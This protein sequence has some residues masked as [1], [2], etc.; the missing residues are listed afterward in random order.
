MHI[1]NKLIIILLIF[2]FIPFLGLGLI[3]ITRDR[4]TLKEQIGTSSLELS[5]SLMRHIDEYFYSKYINIQGWTKNKCLNGITSGD[6]YGNIFQFLAGLAEIHDEYYYITYL[7]TNGQVVASNNID[8]KGRDM[9]TDAGFKK[10]LNGNQ[11]M[12]DVAFN[13]AAGGYAVVMSTPVWDIPEQ[14]EIIGV[15]T[16]ALKWDVVNEMITSLKIGGKEQTKAN[17]IMLTNKDG[18]VISCFDKKEMFSNNLIEAGMKSAKYAQEHKEGYLTETSEHNLSSFATYTYSRKYKDL[19]HLDWNL[20]L[21]Q[22]PKIV[23]AVAG[24]STKTL[25]ITLL[26]TSTLLIIIS[27]LFAKRISRPILAIVSATRAIGKGDLNTKIPIKSNDEIGLLSISF[28]KMV[29]NLKKSN[30]ELRSSEEQNRNVLRTALDGFWVVDIEGRILEVNDA[31]CNLTGYSREE[32]LKMSISEVEALERPEDTEKHIQQVIKTGSDRFE[33]KHRCKDGRIIDI[34]VSVNYVRARGG[35]LFVFIRD[36]T[37]RK[38][39]EK[40]VHAQHAVTQVLAES[41]TL[42]EASPKILQIICTALEWD[43]GEIWEYDQQRKVLFNTEIW[44]VSSLKFPEFK[45]TTKQITFPPKIGLPGRVW[46]SAEPLWIANVVHDTNFLR[47]SVADKEGLHGAFGF[48]I[49]IGSE[50][51]GIIC[52]FSREIREPD[53]DLLDMMTAIG[54]QIGLFIKRKQ[55]EQETKKSEEKYRK[56]METAQDAILCDINGTITDWNKSA[57]E[58]FGYSK[59]EIIGKSVNILV[60][61]K[62][63]KEHQ[64]GLER[65]LKTGE[66]KMIG[67][68]MEVSGI[69]KEGAE[70]PIEISLTG[71]KLGNERYFFTGIIRDISEK[72]K[73]QAEIIR[74]GQLALIGELA[75]GLA[76]EINNPIY[77][78]INYAQLIADESDKD[79]RAHKFGK[80]I[81]EE[82]NRIADL[83]KKFLSLSR[84]TTDKK[85]YVQIYELISNSLKLTKVQLEK[86]NI[87]IKDN[88]PKDIPAIIANPQEIHQVFLNLI[89]N[90]RYALNEKYP[91]KD[92]DKILEISCNKVLIDDYE[93]VRI[94][95]YDRGIGIPEN[96]LNKI[97]SPFFTTKSPAKGTGIGLSISQNIISNHNGKMTIE[98]MPG[99]FTKVVIDLPATELTIKK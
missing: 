83:T 92:K 53:N 46:E 41:I 6:E 1:R 63:K 16:V 50:V 73:L 99:Q 85:K 91:D 79:S 19:P 68:T 42:E 37:E 3:E 93:Y 21:E 80:L 75:A 13:E 52:F 78:I 94:I 51:L 31:Y 33:S 38:K 22:D 62:Y 4:K 70:I 36:I 5:R 15:L 98:S 66:G 26:G 8:L 54:R 71:Q 17:H 44:H 35:R 49:V 77:G 56:L 40:H 47:A 14:S 86:D 88:I 2:S 97:I 29:D 60:P 67:R 30:S 59:D 82:G 28:N 23:F 61:E 25:I 55:A 18:M 69:T 39:A 84:S 27:F 24:L 81:M 87:I 48:P 58:L 20:I 43:I 9:S 7:N 32:L 45:A 64:E 57:E 74:A 96:I 95:F 10:A 90:A 12:Q 65:F 89:Q 34:D 76:H 72:T 11:V